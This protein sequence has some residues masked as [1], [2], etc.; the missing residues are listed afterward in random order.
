MIFKHAGMISCKTLYHRVLHDKN[1]KARLLTQG[2]GLFLLSL[3]GKVF[4][5]HDRGNTP[6]YSGG[7]VTDFH[8][9]P[10]AKDLTI[11]C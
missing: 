10:F 9:V 8:R 4:Q 1:L 6:Q 2:L 11:F 5:W 3:P 7:T